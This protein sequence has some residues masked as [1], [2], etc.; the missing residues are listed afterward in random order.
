MA[1]QNWVPHG[2]IATPELEA[3]YR[4]VPDL[5]PVAFFH[6]LLLRNATRERGPETFNLIH[7]LFVNV[8]F[9]EQHF[10]VSVCGNEP[11]KP[12]DSFALHLEVSDSEN[13]WET[14]GVVHIWAP[15]STYGYYVH[16]LHGDALDTSREYASRGT[17]K[18]FFVFTV[19]GTRMRC[20]YYDRGM[21]RLHGFWN[22]DGANS[23][24]ASYLDIGLDE[25][26]V[27]FW[28]AIQKIKE[29]LG[30]SDASS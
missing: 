28:D 17:N 25:N 27:R 4:A 7:P 8:I 2:L 23:T 29:R 13:G 9:P 6:T 10:R 15:N 12:K 11:W 5:T 24:L 3:R 14:F 16:L 30:T 18:R 22:N 1:D 19:F 21:S 26:N 20:W